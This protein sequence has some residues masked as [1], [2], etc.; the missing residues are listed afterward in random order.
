MI[1]ALLML[2]A[3]IAPPSEP[4]DVFHCSLSNRTVQS[5]L[6]VV[7]DAYLAQSI[8]IVRTALAA[9]TNRLS[10]MVSPQARFTTFAGDVISGPRTAGA[11][12]A[13]EYFSDMSPVNY[14]YLRANAGPLI[15]DPCDSVISE[16][17]LTDGNPATQVMLRFE[18]RGGVLTRVSGSSVDVVEGQLQGGSTHG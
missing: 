12:A 16:L 11:A 8:N 7:H 14:Q 1:G 10:L 18:Y 2:A 15:M 9:D 4:I 5:D 17:S 13:I 6:S 3:G